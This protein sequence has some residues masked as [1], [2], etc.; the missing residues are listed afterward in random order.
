MKN[1]F[2]SKSILISMTAILI[3]AVF[4]RLYGINWDQNQHL[5]PDER[6]LT[7]VTQSLKK[8]AFFAD[9][10]DPKKST[11]NPYNTGYPF[12]VYGTFPIYIVKYA[13]NFIKFD[14]FDY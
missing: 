2:K 8:P 13:A 11:F 12:F 14:S 5:H 4:F 6:F 3:L 10:L 1:F 7:M 9:Y